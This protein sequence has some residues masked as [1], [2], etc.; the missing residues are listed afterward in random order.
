MAANRR[1]IHN[2]T[3]HTFPLSLLSPCF[4][5]NG[6][7]LSSLQSSGTFSLLN[8]AR[9]FKGPCGPSTPIKPAN[10]IAN[11]FFY[12]P[13]FSSPPCTEGAPRH[14]RKTQTETLHPNHNVSLKHL[15]SVLVTTLWFLLP[16]RPPVVCEPTSLIPTPAE[17]RISLTGSASCECRTD[18]GG[19]SGGDLGFVRKPLRCL[20]YGGERAAGRGLCLP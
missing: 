5:F 4:C 20:A 18:C 10:G 11:I 7:A 2:T 9:A 8:P 6:S 13:V 3:Q 17:P 1:R 15:L 16:K 19:G 12:G 14:P